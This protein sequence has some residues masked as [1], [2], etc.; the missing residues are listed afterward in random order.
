MKNTERD[1][2]NWYILFSKT[3]K[4][5]QLCS[6]LCKEGIHAFLPVMEYYRRDRKELDKKIMFP[7]YIFIQ[8]EKNQEEFDSILES[9][10]DRCW[11]LIKQLKDEGKAALT[12]EE[13]EFFH[14]FLDES[15]E[16]KMS[17]GYLNGMNKVIIT[18]GPLVGYEKLIKKMDKHNHLVFLNFIFKDCPVKF[19]LT[20]MTLK[21]LKDRKLYDENIKVDTIS[22]KPEKVQKKKTN[23]NNLMSDTE[24][25]VLFDEELSE[26]VEVN[27]KELISRM[28]QL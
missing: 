1:K 17:Y 19:G 2:L 10:E 13:G 5:S 28:T 7:G 25:V 22:V 12:K 18:H 4:Q 6:L 3:E 14:C 16:A 9:M 11:G 24:T 26:N 15:G 8:S 20:I 21:E 27:L 23:T